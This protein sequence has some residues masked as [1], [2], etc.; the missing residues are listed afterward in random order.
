M[1]KIT[2]IKTICYYAFLAFTG[3]LFAIACFF[4]F[5]SDV[6]FRYL[7]FMAL[8]CVAISAL[9]F[10]FTKTKTAHLPV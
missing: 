6:L 9:L 4:I 10:E 2:I 7:V 5:I 8:L 3:L 1:K